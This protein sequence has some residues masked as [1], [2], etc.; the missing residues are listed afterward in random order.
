MCLSSPQVSCCRWGLPYEDESGAHSLDGE[1]EGET[2]DLVFSDFGGSLGAKGGEEATLQFPEVV[3]D[4]IKVGVGLGRGVNFTLGSHN[5]A[6]EKMELGGALIKGTCH[7]PDG[8]ILDGLGGE[9]AWSDDLLCV[10][11]SQA[12]FRSKSWVGESLGVGPI[13]D[14]AEHVGFTAGRVC[15]LA[16]SCGTQGGALG[17]MVVGG[18]I[19]PISPSL[20]TPRGRVPAG[21]GALEPQCATT[22]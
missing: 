11:P 14:V 21:L 4:L 3:E 16:S 8:L 10:G 1:G 15:S 12:H 5:C 18:S 22:S 9:K 19:T 7:G 20:V 13:S 17:G 2:S 6:W